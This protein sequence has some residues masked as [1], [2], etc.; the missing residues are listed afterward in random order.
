M[1]PT[2]RTGK[3]NPVSLR[4]YNLVVCRGF[5]SE[6][7]TIM[8]LTETTADFNN[9]SPYLLFSAHLQSPKMTDSP[10]PKPAEVCW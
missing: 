6:P 7:P 1:I 10:F 2:A 5:V 9:Q 4:L 8:A 3:S